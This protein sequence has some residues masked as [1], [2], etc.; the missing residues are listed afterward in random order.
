MEQASSGGVT[1]MPPS[2]AA[3]GMEHSMSIR[4]M[5]IG[6]AGALTLSAAVSASAG[7]LPIGNSGLMTATT[8]ATTEIYW[9]RG[10]GGYG[11]GIGFGIAAGALVGAAVASSGYYGYG[12]GP[13][14]GYYYGGPVVYAQPY[15]YQPVY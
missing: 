13:G 2:G 5:A 1:S 10:C 15:A 6:L 9:R 12:Y 11:P 4:L 8:P 14:P 3:T 7:P